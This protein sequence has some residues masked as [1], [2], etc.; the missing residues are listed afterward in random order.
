MLETNRQ[1]RGDLSN[2]CDHDQ[3]NSKSCQ[4]FNL[5]YCT[6]SFWLKAQKKI[7][8]EAINLIYF[9]CHAA[10]RKDFEMKGFPNNSCLSFLLLRYKWDEL[11]CSST[12][13]CF[14]NK[15]KKFNANFCS[16]QVH[17]TCLSVFFYFVSCWSNCRPIKTTKSGKRRESTLS[18]IRRT[19]SKKVEV[20]S[21][22]W[23]SVQV[24]SSPGN[25]RTDCREWKVH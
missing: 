3:R 13:K 20:F 15:E 22:P 1:I 25:N 8:N 5:S 4:V 10:P 7:F 9:P 18:Q 23:L 16:C 19:Y 2:T 6:N 12:N 21:H 24:A 14:Q 11:L 17:V